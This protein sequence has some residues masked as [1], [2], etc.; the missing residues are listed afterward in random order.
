MRILFT[1]AGDT[2][3]VRG[4]HDGAMLHILRHYGADRVIVFLTQ[5]MENKEDTMNCYTRGIQSL[6]PKCPITYIRSGITEPQNYEKLVQIQTEFDKAYNQYTDAEWLLNISSG[7]PQIKS[8]MSFLALD[9]P[10]AKAIQV[11]SPEKSSNRKNHPCKTVDELV[12]MLDVNEDNDSQ[13]SNRCSEPP[14]LLLKRHGLRLQIESLVYNYEY[15]GAFQLVRQNKTLFSEETIHLLQHAV[16]RSNLRWHDA[17]KVVAQYKQQPL[18]QHPSDFSEYFQVME[19]RQKKKQLPDFI[20]KLSP[21]LMGLG[22]QYL[23]QIPGFQLDNCGRQN[24]RNKDSNSF[25][26]RRAKMQENYPRL[27]AYI[28]NELKNR[29]RDGPL[30]FNTIVFICQYYKETQLHDDKKH[31]EIT[32]IFVC[33]R[34]IEEKIRNPLAHTITNITEDKLQEITATGTQKG[35]RST[36]I[37][38]L[39]HQAIRRIQGKDI[40]W[41]YDYLNTCI[42][43]SLNKM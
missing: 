12:E 3:P 16:Y 17:N 25:F 5:D 20:V 32:N 33:L 15:D 8:V 24:Y 31:A 6:L 42:I 29:L 13:A 19:L 11:D 36:D 27:L 23:S 34:S 2:D 39:L 43:D 4:Y 30:Y 10:K 28:E 14:L 38:C 26:I 9:Y 21:I 41:S 22:F 40:P 1:P 18:M 7:T 37:L 35:M